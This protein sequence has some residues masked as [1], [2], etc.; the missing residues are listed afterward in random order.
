MPPSGP[1]LVSS[2]EKAGPLLKAPGPPG[3]ISGV[4]GNGNAGAKGDGSIGFNGGSRPSLPA[5]FTRGQRVVT[6]K[7]I[8]NTVG[9]NSAIIAVLRQQKL[10]TGTSSEHT[11]G[12]GTVSPLLS[13]R[14][15]N[16]K[17]KS[18]ASYTPSSL[19]TPQENE[20]CQQREAQNLDPEILRVGG[21]PDGQ[22]VVYSPDPQAN[23]Y[24]IL[25]CGFGNTIGSVFLFFFKDPGMKVF[26]EKCTLKIQ[27]WNDHEIVASLDQN[28]SGVPDWKI[29]GLFVVGK[30]SAT[31]ARGS[32]YARRQTIQLP[33]LPRTQASLYQQGSP[34]F[35]S[36]VSDY[37][38]L[39]G[40]VA[41]MRQGLP[42]PVAG[43]DQFTLQLP[44]GFVVDSTQTDLLASNTSASV[45]SKPAA[46][47]GNTITVTYPVVSDSSGT[48]TNYYSIYG[49]TIWVTGPAGFIP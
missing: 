14:A 7:R 2:A 31:S 44:P 29:V 8:R 39:N 15:P 43:Q 20:F 5:A 32:F 27:S 13:Q 4:G 3:L 1:K 19:L 46:V 30:K 12:A 48:S 10:A 41:V 49:L 24:T 11:L 23:P 47:N 9:E 26:F 45:T 35:L 17:L 34:Y 36:P 22:D 33:S 38:G 37:Y 40:T 42:G 28:T 6:G 21:K 25:G 16:L 18:I